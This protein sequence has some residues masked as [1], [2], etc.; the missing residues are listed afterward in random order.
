MGALIPPVFAPILGTITS[1]RLTYHANRI[2]ASKEGGPVIM[3]DTHAG[4]LSDADLLAQIRRLAATE[5]E[6]NAEQVAGI[7][8]DTPIVEGLDLDSLKQVMLLTSLEETYGVVLAPA[9][10]DE[11]RALRTVGDLVRIIRERSS[12]ST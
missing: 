3:D 2:A 7:R 8:L 12:A 6:L 11:L 9:T 10:V 4:A 1:A 5:L